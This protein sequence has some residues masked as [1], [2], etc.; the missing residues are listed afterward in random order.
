M[1]FQNL[2]L[3]FYGITNQIKL[4]R[5]QLYNSKELGGLN[6]PNIKTFLYSIKASW[7]KRYIDDNN[8][9]K[10]KIF[11]NKVLAKRGGNIIFDCNITEDDLKTFCGRNPFIHDVLIAWNKLQNIN[12]QSDI[13]KNIIWNNS[14]IK[15]NNKTFYYKD[16]HERGVLYLEHIFDFR[17]NAFYSFQN[18]Q[19]LYQIQLIS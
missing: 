18:M 11:F 17:T 16:W 3:P 6:L 1:T 14:E 19:F 15:N 8:Q 13:R 5:E 2:F 10:W 12:M 4:K 9:A 7:I